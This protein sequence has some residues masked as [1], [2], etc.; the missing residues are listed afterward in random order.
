MAAW[1]LEYYKKGYRYIVGC[2]EAGRG[3]LAGPVVAGA[4]ILNP[5]HVKKFFNAPSWYQQIKDSKLLAPKD[6]TRLAELIKENALAW[7][8]AEVP[9]ATVDAMNIHHASFHAMQEAVQAIFSKR[10]SYATA[11]NFI[12]AI[13]GKFPIPEI[14]LS[15]RPVVNGDRDVLSISAASILAKVH[16]DSLMV[17]LHEAFPQYNFA[18]HKG[19]ATAEH[20]QALLAHGLSPEH[21]VTFCRYNR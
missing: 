13:D 21:R 19:Y 18:Q 1:E 16:R 12:V 10:D 6:R 4:V 14:E 8:V 11:K 9:A 17:K 3:S 5:K 7:S 15:Q 20:R 2:D